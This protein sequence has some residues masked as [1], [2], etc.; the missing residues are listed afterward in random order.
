MAEGEVVVHRA[1]RRPP[2]PHFGDRGWCTR[3]SMGGE[4]DPVYWQPLPKWIQGSGLIW[5]KS[6]SPALRMYHRVDY[7]YPVCLMIRSTIALLYFVPRVCICVV[8]HARTHVRA[9]AHTHTHTHTHSTFA[10]LCACVCVCLYMYIRVV[11]LMPALPQCKGG[12]RRTV[13][14][15]ALTAAHEL[16]PVC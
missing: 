9:R 10:L 3:Q 4:P 13:H 14:Q 6:T 8:V 2:P 16:L 12:R 15:V 1:H 7:T 5:G 11:V